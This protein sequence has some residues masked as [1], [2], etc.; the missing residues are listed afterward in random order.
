MATAVKCSLNTSYFF[1]QLA[2]A[3]KRFLI[4]DFDTTLARL[5]AGQA[6]RFP[7]PLVADLLECIAASARTRLIVASTRPTHEIA[8]LLTCP[9]IEI[10][11][12]DGLERIA[13]ATRG[14]KT[15]RVTFRIDSR[16]GTHSRRTLINHRS[17][18]YPLAYLVGTAGLESENELFIVPELHLTK[19]RGLTAM[20][21]TLI[22]FLA[23]WLRVC[24]GEVC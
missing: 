23:E 12:S 22:Q 13:P 6:P 20:P 7:C 15:Q 14:S 4:L 10:W 2:S 1:Q 11:G 19:T 16:R 18:R 8:P 5:A 17:A 9:D 24:A 3:D 21:E